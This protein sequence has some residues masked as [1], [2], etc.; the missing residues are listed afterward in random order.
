[1]RGGI[2]ADM[3]QLRGE[4]RAEMLRGNTALL[5]WILVFFVSQTAAIA[6]IV[7]LFVS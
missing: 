2:H 3:A 7:R 1:L 6:A 5:K 4:L